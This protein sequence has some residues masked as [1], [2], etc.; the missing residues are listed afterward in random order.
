MGDRGLAEFLLSIARAK[1]I[2]PDPALTELA[3]T[4]DEASLMLKGVVTVWVD[5]GI[6][7]ENGVGFPDRVIGSGFFIDKRGYIL[8]NHHVIES[9]V[10]P[11]YEGYSR[12]YIR[13]SDRPEQRIPAAGTVCGSSGHLSRGD[14]GICR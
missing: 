5:R 3:T 4:A 12:L 1:G 10:D 8:T 7:I 9:E 2:E 6:K 11:E 14:D 13:T